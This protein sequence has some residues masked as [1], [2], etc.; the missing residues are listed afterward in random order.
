MNNINFLEDFPILK[1]HENGERLVYLDS[2]ATTQKPKQVIKA[3]KNY[4]KNINA[5][6]HRG[7]YKLSIEATKAYDESREK[8]RKF[9]DAESSKEIIFTKNATEGFNL[10]SYSYGMEN[11]NEGDEIVISIAEHHSNLIPWQI[12]AK[13][14]KATL[15][16][17]YLNDDGEIPED[18]IKNKIT[19]K[20]KLVSITHVSNALGTINPVKEIIDYAHSMGAKVI[21]DGSQSVPH[22]KV[23]VRELDADFLVFSGHKLLGPM[24]IG[25][26]YG[27]EE[28]LS[29]MIPYIVGGD[30][31]EYVYEQSATFAELPSKFEGG[32]QNVEGAVGLGAAIDYINEIGIEKIDK[33]E[34]DLLIYAIDKLD[35]LPYVT[36]YGPKNLE[37]RG[38]I[39]SFNIEGVHPHDVSSVFDSLN[40]A[41]RSGH[42][43]AQPLMRFMDINATCRASFYFYNTKEDVDK[44]VEAAK[45][46]YEM[47]SKW[48]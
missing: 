25:V 16:Y 5:N 3:I 7:A 38:G 31:I 6:P 22:M 33:I 17:M 23:S 8:V 11:I 46:T 42:H 40:V 13:A 37:H 47:F 34:K 29:H 35:K 2:A 39:I 43:C 32:T 12:V 26:V 14:K 9:I 28:L 21:V 48:R 36:I 19:E 4:Y 30:M 1:A 10:L 18:E 44:L 41:I 27:K 24:G 20:T 45:K 15:K